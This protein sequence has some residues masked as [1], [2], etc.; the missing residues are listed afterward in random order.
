MTGRTTQK[1]VGQ[2]ILSN[3][4]VCTSTPVAK[5]GEIVL[6]STKGGNVEEMGMRRAQ[7]YT[8]HGQDGYTEDKPW[9]GRIKDKTGIMTVFNRSR[10]NG[11]QRRTENNREKDRRESGAIKMVLYRNLKG[12]LGGRVSVKAITL[13]LTLI[14]RPTERL[15]ASAS[16][17]S[18]RWSHQHPTLDT[19]PNNHIKHIIEGLLEYLFPMNILS[20]QKLTMRRALPKPRDISFKCFV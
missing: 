12:H 17:E 5:S 19:T 11:G 16:A 13:V 14:P 10:R 3:I 20:K 4:Q 1:E 9:V 7:R 2:G 6:A 8:S 15:L 18:K